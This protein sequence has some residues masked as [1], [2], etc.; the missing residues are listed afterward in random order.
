MC[1]S[2]MVREYW[3]EEGQGLATKIGACSGSRLF[4][5]P[6]QG[7]VRRQESLEALSKISD[8]EKPL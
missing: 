3:W 5:C 7:D 8:S 4:V 2:Q 1:V 6:G